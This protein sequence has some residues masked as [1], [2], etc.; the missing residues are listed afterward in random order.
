MK[1]LLYEIKK[2]QTLIGKYPLTSQ[3]EQLQYIRD[4]TLA[5]HVE[6]TEFLQEL[7]WKPWIKKKH[8]QFSTNDAAGELVDV[9]IFILN[10]WTALDTRLDLEQFIAEKID[11]NIERLNT[12]IHKSHTQGE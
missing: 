10:L 6:L 7:P 9:F 11:L 2:H 8:Q 3:D 1:E 5:A 12:G 4:L